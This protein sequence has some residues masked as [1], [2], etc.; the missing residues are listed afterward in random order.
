M[1]LEDARELGAEASYSRVQTS[2]VGT[3]LEP[4]NS[5]DMIFA[6]IEFT[7]L[8]PEDAEAA[9]GEPLED[10][11][12]ED[13]DGWMRV[14]HFESCHVTFLYDA[15]RQTCRVKNMTIDNDRLEGPRS[16]RVGDTFASVLNRF[17]HSEG[18]YSDTTE[19]LYGDENGST[20]GMA[21][22]GEEAIILRYG[23][24]SEEGTPVIMRLSFEQIYLTEILLQVND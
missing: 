16:V 21:E 17:R 20:F 2:Y 5:E 13:G 8:T 23:A 11:E 15:A 1:A 18:E 12:M 10:V 3:D 7:S 14:M 6:G 19:I 22:Y 4:F 9:F 24:E